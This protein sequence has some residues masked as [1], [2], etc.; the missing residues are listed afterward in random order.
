MH[1]TP[2]SAAV[3]RRRRAYLPILAEVLVSGRERQ[4]YIAVIERAY[5]GIR[6][7]MSQAH[8]PP[9]FAFGVLVSRIIANAASN[10]G[11]AP[12]IAGVLA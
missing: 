10:S 12:T 2:A 8:I 5:A 9:V 7:A 1:H 4:L 6:A 11:F 3:A